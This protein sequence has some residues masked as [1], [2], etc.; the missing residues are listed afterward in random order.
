MGTTIKDLKTVFHTADGK[1][2]SEIVKSN[3]E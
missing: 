1:M 3:L 2:I